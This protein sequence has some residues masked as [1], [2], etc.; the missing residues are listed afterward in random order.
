MWPYLLISLM[1]ICTHESMII[2]CHK[3]FLCYTYTFFRCTYLFSERSTWRSSR[4]F[5]LF[6]RPIW[7]ER[8]WQ[9]T[10]SVGLLYE[11]IFA[12]VFFCFTH[13]HDRDQGCQKLQSGKDPAYGKAI[14]LSLLVPTWFPWT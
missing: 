4:C 6:Q 5:E 7:N 2:L 12:A 11:Y 10:S 13:S 8:S 3:T 1:V 9:K 14:R